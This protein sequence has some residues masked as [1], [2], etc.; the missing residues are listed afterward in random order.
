M[1]ININILE[2]A[3]E[4]AHKKI[5]EHFEFEAKKIYEWVSDEESRYTEEAQELFNEW[6]DYYYDFLLKLKE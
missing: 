6:Y 3:S 2:V 4:L 1:N 5:E